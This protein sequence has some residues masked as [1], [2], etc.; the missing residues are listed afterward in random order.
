M[1][2]GA[3]EIGRALC[4]AAVIAR[5][6][7][8]DVGARHAEGSANQAPPPC[9]PCQVRGDAIERIAAMRFTV[10]RRG[11][12]EKA[13]ERLLKQ[14]VSQLT[15]AGDPGEVCP[16]SAG[17]PLV[18]CAEGVLVHHEARAGV[19]MGFGAADIGKRH[20]TKHKGSDSSFLGTGRAVRLGPKCRDRRFDQP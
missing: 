4:C 17:R 20:V 3:R 18:E 10:V 5:R 19:V 16:D 11:G 2:H 9:I 7:A 12:A 14:I 8:L 15:V 6:N 13:I 1:P